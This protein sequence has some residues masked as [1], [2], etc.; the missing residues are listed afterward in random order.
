MDKNIIHLPDG[1][2]VSY[3]EYGAKQGLPVI[4]LHGH[5]G[6]RFEAMPLHS[7]ALKKNIRIIA[8]DRP[9]MGASTLVENRTMTDYA[10]DITNMADNLHIDTFAVIGFSGGG[11]YAL[12]CAQ[13]M[14]DQVL[15]CTIVSG[16]GRTR[17]FIALLSIWLPRLI[18]PSMKKMF[19]TMEKSAETV[20][21][22]GSKWQ[23]AE[24][25]I[26]KNDAVRKALAQSLFTAF[27]QGTKGA[28]IDGTLVGSRDWGFR[29][30]EISRTPIF[31]W[32]GGE[33]KQ[34]KPSEATSMI[35]TIPKCVDYFYKNDGH[36]STLVNHAS[37]ILDN[38]AK[39][40]T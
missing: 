16:V 35:K 8:P 9:G 7:D 4:Y 25:S 32:H 22:L 20:A 15:S 39:H 5:P 14:P 6:S 3:S 11:P 40:A 29:P 37:D 23:G 34:V 26:L 2:V 27:E 1:R 12:A 36:I 33:D 10:D 13:R 18:M 21:R 38:I 28:V 24:K 30:Q 17:L 19:T 31:W